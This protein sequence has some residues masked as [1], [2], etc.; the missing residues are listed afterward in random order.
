MGCGHNKIE[1]P[2][3]KN[4]KI[5]LYEDY[6][7]IKP[8]TFIISFYNLTWKKK[9][10]ICIFQKISEKEFQKSEINNLNI[11]LENALI[12][13]NNKMNYLMT[14]NQILYYIY[15]T[16]GVI[17]TRNYHKINYYINNYIDNIINL[18]FVDISIIL[19]EKEYFSIYEL[20]RQSKY[21]FNLNMKEIDFTKRNE[22]T[23]EGKM[24]QLSD[25]E[26]IEDEIEKEESNEK[27][28]NDINIKINMEHF[29]G[30]YKQNDDD[31]FLGIKNM[32]KR[33]T[34]LNGIY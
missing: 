20:K 12:N 13:P 15:C 24:E 28:N 11:I 23:N 21:Y 10:D 27:K 33:E 34:I 6:E 25:F 3:E 31:N 17:I 14:K 4:T 16:N 18:N 8:Y 22:L 19:E 1:I 2:V 5:K 26:D 29:N 7:E 32:E 30:N 9:P